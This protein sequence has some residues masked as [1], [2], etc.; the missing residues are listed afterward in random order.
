ME[1]MASVQVARGPTPTAE[2][3]MVVRGNAGETQIVHN[4]PKP[5]TEHV[6]EITTPPAYGKAAVRADGL[7]RVCANSNVAGDDAMIVT[8]A[9][10]ADPSRKLN[11]R[12]PII[13]ADGEP[14][15]ECDPN[16]FG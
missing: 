4:D 2:N 15:D 16:D 3:I 12:V 14:A 6:Y 8:V 5:N 13:I 9:D 11:V 7:A 1:T 10:K